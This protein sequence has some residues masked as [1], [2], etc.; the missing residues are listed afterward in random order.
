MGGMFANSLSGVPKVLV[1]PSFH[2][3][4]SMRKKIGIV[5]FFKKRADGAVEFEVTEELCDVYEKFERKQFAFIHERDTG[6]TFGLFGTQD[7][8]VDCKDEFMRYFGDAYLNIYCGH[9]LTN[10]TIRQDLIPTLAELV[11]RNS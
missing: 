10:E 2:V 11:A 7:D 5:K 3:S 4:E 8:V 1:N 9:R 6:E